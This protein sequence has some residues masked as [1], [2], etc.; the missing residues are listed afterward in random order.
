MKQAFFVLC[1]FVLLT[2]SMALSDSAGDDEWS[3]SPA[4][5]SSVYSVP[6]Q[7]LC[8]RV[9]QCGNECLPDGGCYDQCMTRAKDSKINLDCK[10]VIGCSEFKSCL[11][12]S[13]I[14]S[15]SDEDD[16]K[17]ACGCNISGETQGGLLT[18]G[19]IL[20]GLFAT[21]VGIRKR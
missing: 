10:D 21:F 5:T 11:C 14:E 17:D 12:A 7:D 13:L 4:P 8:Q 3:D 19:M 9:Y 16:E 20:I 6:C 2:P 18:A 15:G 1:V